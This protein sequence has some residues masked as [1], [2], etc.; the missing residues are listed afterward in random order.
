M[1]ARWYKVWMGA[2][3]GLWLIPVICVVIGVLIS[4]GT[5]ALDRVNDYELV[6]Q[7]VIGTPDAVLAILQ[8][9]AASMVSLTALVLTIVLVVVQLAMG[10]SSPRIVQRLLRDRPS[11]FAI[12]LFVASFVHSLLAIREVDLGSDGHPGHVPGV[13][14]IVTFALALASIAVLVMYVHHVGQ[15]LRVSALVELAGDQTRRMVDRVYPDHGDPEPDEHDPAIVTAVKS[16]V[17]AKVWH[18]RL[19]ETASEGRCRLE[20]IP[21]MGDF[22]PAGGRI[23]LI[24]GD[25]SRLDLKK[26]NDAVILSMERSLVEDVGYGMRLLVD[27][28]ERALSDSPFQDPTTAVQTIDRLHDILRQ[29]ARRPLPDGTHRE[30]DG[31]IRLTERVMTWDAYVHLAF[32]ELRLVGAG[33]PQVAR[34]LQSAL[35]DLL[36]VAPPDRRDVLELQ[37]TLLSDAAGGSYAHAVDIARARRPDASGIGAATAAVK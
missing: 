18:E 13:A 15:A 10:Q 17:L 9:V 5:I 3:S 22:I 36:T 11:Q 28:G 26:V 6:S 8:T 7:E 30:P 21:A 23:F 24:H 34:R 29:L 27:M 14:V 4:L 25:P 31:T 12:G 33:S 1:S 20:L 16:G 19:V 2:K 35:R 37:L 32:D